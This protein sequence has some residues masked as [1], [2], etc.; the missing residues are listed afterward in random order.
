MTKIKLANESLNFIDE[1]YHAR[2]PSDRKQESIRTYF[3][4]WIVPQ[5][6]QSQQFSRSTL[7]VLLP[8]LEMCRRFDSLEIDCF[9]FVQLQFVCWIAAAADVALI[10]SS[11]SFR[12]S[13]TER[14]AHWGPTPCYHLLLI[15]WP[16]GRSNLA[17]RWRRFWE[18]DPIL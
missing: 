1:D 11:H 3:H 2:E 12:L 10:D 8:L 13:P 7:G 15:S 16:K 9:G 17:L 5:P 6:T 18:R 4:L 14:N